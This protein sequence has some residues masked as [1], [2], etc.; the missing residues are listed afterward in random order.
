M[1]HRFHRTSDNGFRCTHCQYYVI[2][3]SFITGVRNRN[4]CPLCLWSK[5][6]DQFQAGDRLAVCKGNM[7]PIGLYIKH[8]HKKYGFTQLGEL[9]LIHVCVGCGKVSINRIAADDDAITIYGIFTAS[10][11]NAISRQYKVVDSGIRV[12]GVE[13]ELLVRGQLFGMQ[14]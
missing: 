8:T 2:T 10:Y 9:M 12:L 14:S 5:H 3:D 13:D 1:K 4:H 11:K 6:L 7:Q